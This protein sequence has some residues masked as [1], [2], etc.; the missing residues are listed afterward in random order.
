MWYRRRRVERDCVHCGVRAG[1]PNRPATGEGVAGVEAA[2]EPNT[3]FVRRRTEHPAR[4]PHT[5]PFAHADALPREA[6]ASG[7]RRRRWSGSQ[8]PAEDG[9]GRA[10]SGGRRG[11][12]S[13]DTGPARDGH[14]PAEGA[15]SKVDG[16]FKGG[17][18]G[19]RRVH[20]RTTRARPAGVGARRAPSGRSGRRAAGVILNG[21]S[22]PA[23]P[24]GSVRKERSGRKEGPRLPSGGKGLKLHQSERRFLQSRMS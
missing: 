11:D 10:G 18:P 4:R 3:R 8:Q 7:G 23:R 16:S 19:V 2:E 15:P 20:S 22:R 24:G 12:G 1:G 21:R 14:G 6:S 17:C 9:A 13:P 5:L